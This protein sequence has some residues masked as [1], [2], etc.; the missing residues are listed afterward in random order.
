MIDILQNAV[1]GMISA[2]NRW[3]KEVEQT[4]VKPVERAIQPKHEAYKK[5][6][7]RHKVIEKK[8]KKQKRNYFL[9]E[10]E[11]SRV[12]KPPTR[13]ARQ[14][15][16]RT[17]YKVSKDVRIG[18]KEAEHRI[19]Y[20]YGKVAKPTITNKSYQPI[21]TLGLMLLGGGIAWL[22]ISLK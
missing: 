4:I 19:E 3:Y 10:V 11:S 16:T 5:A 14:K 13:K 8:S 21:D 9:R 22:L 20:N 12:R 18:E 7:A 15:K 6:V 17:E 1:Y 2:Y